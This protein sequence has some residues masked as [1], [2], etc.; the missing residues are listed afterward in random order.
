MPVTAQTAVQAA[1]PRRRILLVFEPPDGGVPEA[2]GH[3]AL[4]LPALGWDVEVAGPGQASILPALN[5]AGLRVHR[6]PLRRGYGR[7]D[8]D[9]AALSRLVSLVR[10]GGFDLVHA[11]SS[12]AGVLGRL[13][14][15]VAGVPTIYSPHCFGFVGPVSLPRR[16]F[17]LALELSLRRLTDAT[18]CVCEDERVTALRS[19]VAPASRLWVVLNGAPDCPVDEAADPDL[20]ALRGDGTLAAAVSSLREQKGL[21]VL[22]EAVPRVLGA[23]PEARV[24][25]VGNGPLADKLRCHAATLGLDTEPRFALLPFMGPASRHLRA[26]DVFV[27]PSRWE[28]FPI[29]ILEAMACGVP[30]VCTDVGGTPEAVDETSGRLVP[31]DDPSALAEAI[32]EL[33]GDAALRE[34]LG[35]SAR[36][37]HSADFRVARMVAQTEAIYARLVG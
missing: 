28:A 11:H 4:G 2:V 23:L 16:T 17:V 14:A 13:A 9:A 18:L 27:L 31:P 24:A 1:R 22:L 33:L 7:P 29:G 21:D 36:R 26:L 12:K 5:A 6:L 37:R 32:I 8:R 20:T 19:R 25:I 30:Q 3:L 10:R 15:K 34:R 35:H